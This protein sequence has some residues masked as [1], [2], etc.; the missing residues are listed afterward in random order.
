MA[1]HARSIF[2]LQ[3]TM[4]IVVLYTTVPETLQALKMAA[5]LAHDLSARIRLLVLEVVP[6]PLPLDQP[7]VTV[8]FTQQRFRTLAESASS[9]AKVDTKVDIHFVR[10]AEK[11]IESL[12]EPH[13]IVVLGGR[14]SPWTKVW[15]TVQGRISKRLKRTGHAVVYAS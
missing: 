9:K 10:D 3:A 15:P 4:E 13:S 5:H 1:A 14:C 12:L 11:A 6:Y 2:T 8:P 7:D